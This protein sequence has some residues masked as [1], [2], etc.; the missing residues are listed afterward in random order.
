MRDNDG[1]KLGDLTFARNY[2]YSGLG[3]PDL[4][5]TVVLQVNGTTVLELAASQQDLYAKSN[6]S[7]EVAEQDK[8]YTVT[9]HE[10]WTLV[11]TVEDVSTIDKPV[12]ADKSIGPQPI[13]RTLI[14]QVD[15][16]PTRP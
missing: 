1:T 2:S 11:T 15:V 10:G 3:S 8:H 4:M 13:Y 9:S 14:L 5:G 6:P 16:T 12:L 7:Y